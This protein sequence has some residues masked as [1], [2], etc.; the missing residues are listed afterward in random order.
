M[1]T[2]RWRVVQMQRPAAKLGWKKDGATK[3]GSTDGRRRGLS[4]R[5]VEKLLNYLVK[6]PYCSFRDYVNT[7]RLAI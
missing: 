3:S 5:P 2:G 4:G 1:N 7:T 6:Y